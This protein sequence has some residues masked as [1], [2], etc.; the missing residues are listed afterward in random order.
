MENKSSL[1]T[2][3]VLG[4]FDYGYE[5]MTP[6][7]FEKKNEGSIAVFE[8]AEEPTE[9]PDFVSEHSGD[10]YWI[11]KDGLYRSGFRWSNGDDARTIGQS[12]WRLDISGLD[13]WYPQ[14]EEWANNNYESEKQMC[15]YSRWD[16]MFLLKNYK[17]AD[18]PEYDFGHQVDDLPF[19]MFKQFF[20]SGI[21]FTTR[22]ICGESVR[23][24]HVYRHRNHDVYNHGMKILQLKEGRTFLFSRKKS[25]T[26][27]IIDGP[28]QGDF[29]QMIQFDDCS[30]SASFNTKEEG[31]YNGL[32]CQSVGNC[33][34]DEYD[35]SASGEGFMATYNSTIKTG[36]LIVSE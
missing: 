3:E 32:F 7:I 6:E 21:K 14:F 36:K 8:L 10:K 29:D 25:K 27:T 16:N 5:T 4:I 15:G 31:W 22:T 24:I 17:P 2:L 30:C 1:H 13:E 12:F 33:P 23:T 20:L 34:N 11:C 28:D 35:I 19:V 26:L 9:K 18:L